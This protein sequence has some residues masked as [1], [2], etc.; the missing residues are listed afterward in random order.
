MWFL[1]CMLGAISIGAL[2][3]GIEHI[4]D[5]LDKKLLEELRAK[6]LYD[7]HGII[8]MEKRRLSKTWKPKYLPGSE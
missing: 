5:C 8:E 2:F 7:N 6:R 4:Q 1:V 3:Y